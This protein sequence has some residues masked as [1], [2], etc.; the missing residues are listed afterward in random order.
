MQFI[1]NLMKLN[2]LIDDETKQLFT[3]F[4][5]SAL[6]SDNANEFIRNSLRRA[7]SEDEPE[8]VK[9]QCTVMTEKTGA[10]RTRRRTGQ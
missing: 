10:S 8:P 5:V 4:C 2:E 3:Q 7:L 9:V 1:V 6:N